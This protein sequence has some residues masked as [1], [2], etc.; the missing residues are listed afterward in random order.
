M[1]IVEK[2]CIFVHIVLNT[3]G[4]FCFS[5]T[6]S[7]LWVA[8]CRHWG[9]LES[10]LHVQTMESL[11]VLPCAVIRKRLSLCKC[12][13]E[14]V[15]LNFDFFKKKVLLCYNSMSSSVVLQGR[16]QDGAN[17]GVAW[18]GNAS[19]KLYMSNKGNDN[20]QGMSLWLSYANER[21]NSVDV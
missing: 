16:R 18:Q 19:L 21:L 13:C 14:C 2:T 17:H 5:V 4:H 8:V 9:F 6:L 3:F 15:C 20:T 1:V 11:Y 7:A 10:L 12:K